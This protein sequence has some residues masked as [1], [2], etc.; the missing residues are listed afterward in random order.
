MFSLLF[1]CRTSI[2]STFGHITEL[3]QSQPFSMQTPGCSQIRAS[4]KLTYSVVTPQQS[5][6]TECGSLDGKPVAS[7]GRSD[8]PR[9]H[10][11]CGVPR[12]PVCSRIGS[13]TN[14]CQSHLLSGPP[15]HRSKV[16]VGT[17]FIS[18]STTRQAQMRG[19]P[20]KDNPRGITLRFICY[21]AFLS[22][23]EVTHILPSRPDSTF[24]LTKAQTK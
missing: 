7:A 18:S 13:W 4:P 20:R 3:S 2:K 19:F 14:Q 16:Y 15:R 17:V 9:H 24:I 23:Q 5:S 1:L 8:R 21:F 12:D 11:K 6:P 22:L 10:S